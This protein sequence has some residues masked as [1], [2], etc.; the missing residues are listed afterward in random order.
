MEF[1]IIFIL[2][3]CLLSFTLG[4]FNGA[5]VEQGK[6]FSSN[7]VVVTACLSVLLTIV[8]GIF[9]ILGRY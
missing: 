2:V 5:L 7:L 8:G 6:E 4:N 9:Y 3:S 1:K